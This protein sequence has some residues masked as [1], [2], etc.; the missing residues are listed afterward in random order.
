MFGGELGRWRRRA[1]GV[2]GDVVFLNAERDDAFAALLL[3][4]VSCRL[5][6]RPHPRLGRQPR[7]SPHLQFGGLFLEHRVTAES[8]KRPGNIRSSTCPV[9]KSH[10]AGGPTG[11]FH[12]PCPNA[13]SIV[14]SLPVQRRENLGGDWF[15]ANC[16]FRLS[17]CVRLVRL[18]ERQ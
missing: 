4:V 6:P 11:S 3:G 16:L 14:G 15:C 13:R 1:E 12:A 7:P 5:G 17:V 18:R 10:T 2:R 8:H 9:S